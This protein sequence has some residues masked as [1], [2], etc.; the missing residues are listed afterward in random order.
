[1]MQKLLSIRKDDTE[2][3]TEYF[4]RIN[5]ATND[6]ISLAPSSLTVP[7]IV[8]EISI[9][10]AISGL[11]QAEYGAFTSSVLLLGKLDRRAIATAFQNKDL[12][13]EASL[14]SSALTTGALATSHMKRTNSNS[15]AT[16]T[17]CKRKGHLVDKCWISHPELRPAYINQRW[18]DDTNEKSKP[19][20]RAQEAKVENDVR[21]VATNASL[22]TIHLHVPL[23]DRWNTD[24]GA[25]N[26]M[27]P[28]RDWLHNYEPHRTSIYLANNEI[29]YSVG[30]G[31]VKYG[32]TGVRRRS[33]EC[34]RRQITRI[35][36]ST[37]VLRPR[38]LLVQYFRGPEYKSGGQG[39]RRTG[40]VP[41][42]QVDKEFKRT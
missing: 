22:S 24:T 39:D 14:A 18:R 33:M 29:V 3:L 21:D 19:T 36:A 32:D 34:T 13:R 27:T 25:T 2:S 10:A 40:G 37:Y 35:L 6:L 9:H 12:K 41:N 11:H 7:D 1:V 5:S 28:R 23:N 17:V 31:D 26:H 16:C 20:N 4:T 42:V 30:R 8:N 15:N 38:K